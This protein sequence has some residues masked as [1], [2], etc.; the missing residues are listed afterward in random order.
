[1]ASES[2]ALHSPSLAYLGL[3]ADYDPS[4]STSPVEFLSRHLHSLPPHILC[5]EFST[6]MTP[7]QRTTLSG[8]RNRRLKYTQSR[9]P[10]LAYDEARATWPLLW[11]GAHDRA[12]GV[13]RRA[14]DDERR[15]VDA[16]FIGGWK[17]HVRKLGELLAGY[18]EERSWEHAAAVRRQQRTEEEFVPEE[19]S[20]SEEEDEQVEQPPVDEEPETLEQSKEAFE[21]L[22]AE[23]FIY[24]LLDVR[25]RTSASCLRLTSI[26]STSLSTTTQ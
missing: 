1:M 9:P 22:V 4:P 11:R 25:P 5:A 13:Q 8:V 20:D 18:E 10:A 2:S 16:E 19:D 21:R 12:G 7:K 26:P 14:A 24:G 23:R 17:P 15:W 3:P 6:R